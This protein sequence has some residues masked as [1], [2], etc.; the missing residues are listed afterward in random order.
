VF[1]LNKYRNHKQEGKGRSI[2]IDG[3]NMDTKPGNI[4]RS[5]VHECA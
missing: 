1:V 5:C 2:Y 3:E 4:Q